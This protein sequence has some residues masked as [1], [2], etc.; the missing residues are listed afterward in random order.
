MRIDFAKHESDLITK[1][2]GTYK[3]RKKRKEIRLE[4]RL[5]KKMKIGV[6]KLVKELLV[7]YKILILKNIPK[8]VKK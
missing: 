3:E 6:D 1:R 7:P 2:D 4:P 5:Q 8:S